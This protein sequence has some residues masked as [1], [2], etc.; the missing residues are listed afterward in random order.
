MRWNRPSQR[1]VLS[2]DESYLH[3]VAQ[4][5]GKKEHPAFENQWAFE[6]RRLHFLVSELRREM[7]SG[8]ATG[9]L[10]GDHLGIALSIVLIRDHGRDT[11]SPARLKGGISRAR[12]Q[13]VVDY[14]AANAHEEI[15]LDDLA[16]VANMSR[17]HFVRQFHSSMGVTPYRYVMDQRLQAAKA[18]L[19]LDNRSVSDIALETGFKTP[20]HVTR[21][22]RRNRRHPL[23]VEAS[24]LI[25]QDCQTK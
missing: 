9:P 2:I 4:E 17:F 20:S 14:I 24:D 22:F 12:L 18:Q 3:R 23:G 10:Y 6:N 13:P 19:R 21:F 15:T 5:L 11:N 7:E 16:R 1:V 25:W 8:W